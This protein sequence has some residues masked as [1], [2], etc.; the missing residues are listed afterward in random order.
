V[1]GSATRTTG[2]TPEWPRPHPVSRV[3]ARDAPLTCEIGNERGAPSGAAPVAG[4]G[5]SGLGGAGACRPGGSFS[6]RRWS[7]FPPAGPRPAGSLGA[8]RPPPRC[9]LG[10][11]DPC[12]GPTDAGAWCAANVAP[13]S[14]GPAALRDRHAA[15]G[16]G[17]AGLGPSGAG[18]ALGR[19]HRRSGGRGAPGV[20]GSG[21]PVSSGGARSGA[22][23]PRAG[24]RRDHPPPRS[25]GADSVREHSLRVKVNCTEGS[26]AARCR[27]RHVKWRTF[28][29]RSLG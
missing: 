4:S 23:R 1:R 12:P 3:G 18:P 29:V 11:I 8:C 27:A 7:P 25:R 14:G 13:R 22:P 5:W 2:G 20:D 19:G 15:P 6:P 17:P 24:V 21:A 16:V 28:T 9:S 26:G 10:P